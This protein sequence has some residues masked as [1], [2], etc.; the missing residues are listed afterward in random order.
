MEDVGSLVVA[1]RDGARDAYG[2]L[3][4]RFADM[5]YAAAVARVGDV[6]LAHDV[7]QE[8]FIEAHRC[9][10]KLEH[11]EAFA[12]WFRVIVFRQA[13]RLMQQRGRASWQP[14]GIDQPSRQPGPAAALASDEL[15]QQLHAALSQLT[16]PQRVVTTLYYLDAYTTTEI[17]SFLNISA[18]AVKKRLHDARRSL[19]TK[20]HPAMQ[21][22]LQRH[23]P[24]NKPQFT[25]EVQ[26]RLGDAA[27]KPAGDAPPL[28]PTVDR[29]SEL[30]R[31][32]RRTP[33]DASRNALL[34]HYLPVV[35]KHAQRVASRLPRRIES[36]DLITAGCFGL[37]D[38]IDAFD[39]QRGVKFETYCATRVRGAIMD[40]LRAMDWAPRLV[41]QRTA[42]YQQ[43]ATSLHARL[44]EPPTDAQIAAEL[45]VDDNEFRKIRHDARRVNVTSLERLLTSDQSDGRELREMDFLADPSQADPLNNLKRLSL[46]QMLTRGMSRS[47]R[48]ILVLYYYEQMN[49]A[50]IGR[51]LG[52]SESRVSQLHK[53]LLNRLRAQLSLQR[54]A[55]EFE[56]A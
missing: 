52:F 6:H 46:R 45:G 18:A 54:D 41:R 42:R 30:W 51:T 50:E 33:G 1:A 24:S 3:V 4:E 49:M 12:G 47:E 38:A 56:V 2:K 53:H 43:A 27:E 26:R 15:H 31:T 13:A 28:E 11:P 25:G 39:P 17:A 10:D 34:E 19:H 20:L 55:D 48:L 7:T 44:G 5:A 35:R 22:G 21:D 36:D 23:R 16:E 9:L 29:A 40:E 14:L 8:A 37:V 32:Y